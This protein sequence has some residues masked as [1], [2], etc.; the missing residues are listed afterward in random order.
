M[1]LKFYYIQ[2]ALLPLLLVCPVQAKEP[3]VCSTFRPPISGDETLGHW[4]LREDRALKDKGCW[5]KHLELGTTALAESEQK[6]D[7]RTIMLL[8]LQLASSSFYLGDY[9]HS[10]KLAARA[11]REGRQQQNKAVQA[12]A[13]YLQS[14]IARAKGQPDAVS[15]AEDA[16]TILQKERMDDPVLEG[17]VHFNLGAALSDIPPKKLNQSKQHLK[18]AY[19]LFV[20]NKRNHDALRAGL[21]WTRVEYLQGHYPEALKLIKSLELWVDGPRSKM[22]YNYQLAKV[23][24]RLKDWRK[25][26]HYAMEALKLA[27][28]LDASR[29][30]AR[31]DTLLLAINQHR[32][33]VD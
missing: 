28:T 29:D 3:E 8:S 15:L 9:D 26:N 18:Q 23:L 14:A 1:K 12:E 16:L 17:K 2:W 4:L 5:H 22:L 13:L 24:H 19:S 25:A 32:F 33:V 27:E 20:A 30:K 31:I 10:F 21:R 6:G 7:N 11:L